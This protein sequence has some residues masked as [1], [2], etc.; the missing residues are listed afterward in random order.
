MQS[1]SREER[2]GRGNEK[3][4]GPKTNSIVITL[5]GWSC[6]NWKWENFG[7]VDTEIHRNGSTKLWVW[8]K[9]VGRLRR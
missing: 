8:Q 1:A 2:T 6:F 9:Y 7:T 5:C 3:K 4:Q